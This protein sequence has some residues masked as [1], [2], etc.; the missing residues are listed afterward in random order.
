MIVA[1]GEG[2]RLQLLASVLV[3]LLISD[4]RSCRSEPGPPL[5]VILQLLVRHHL[6]KTCNAFS[7]W[8]SR[9]NLNAFRSAPATFKASAFTG[10]AC[11]ASAR[12][13]AGYATQYS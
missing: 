9:C 13:E 11:A 10:P 2:L 8:P 5:G 1:D 7:N 6:S 4:A 12:S 3:V